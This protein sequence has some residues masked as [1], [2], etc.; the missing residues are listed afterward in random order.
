LIHAVQARKLSKK[1]QQLFDSSQPSRAAKKSKSKLPLHVDALHSLE[2]VAG[3]LLLAGASRLSLARN[4]RP[5]TVWHMR[6][7]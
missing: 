3:L 4:V 6:Y 1:A 7:R 2:R 5:A